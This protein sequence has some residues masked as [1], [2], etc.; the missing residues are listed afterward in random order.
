M[1]CPYCLSKGKMDLF[2]AKEMMF[3]RRTVFEYG[4][5]K[6]CKSC[7]L[8][9]PL[10]SFPLEEYYGAGYYSFATEKINAG[11]IKRFFLRCRAQ[12]EMGVFNPL[13]ALFHRIKPGPCEIWRT[14]GLKPSSKVLDVGC[15]SGSWLFQASFYG[16]R[17][18]TGCDPFI[19]EDIIDDNVHIVKKEIGAMSGLFDVI[20]FHH[21]FEHV[22]DPRGDLKAARRL[23]RAGGR[24]VV[25]CPT[26][27]SE[28]FEHYR[29]NWVQLD[30]P[31]HLTIPSRDGMRKLATDCG[32]RLVEM[33]DDSTE[34]QF[35]G[36]E[37]YLRDIPMSDS[38]SPWRGGSL[39]SA[40][41]RQ[42]YAERAKQLNDIN[43]GDQTAFI[44]EAQ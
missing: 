31:R 3:G 18:L 28:A 9:T 27:S 4:L 44:L 24:C 11:K 23:Q 38:S 12:Y 16:I 34:F 1:E 5:C 36:S 19:E 13:G 20:L 21:S 10:S 33:H 6:S 41:E 29:E 35:W 17:S 32:Y 2:H 37:Q 30:P 25:R 14:Y 26:T 40:E 39:F 8:V 42:K 7:V 43:R 22:P 15:G